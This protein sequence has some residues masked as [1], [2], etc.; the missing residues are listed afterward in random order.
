M[1]ERGPVLL[2]PRKKVGYTRLE[3]KFRRSRVDYVIGTAAAINMVVSGGPLT[4][5][6]K[7][8]THPAQISE[9]PR[10]AAR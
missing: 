2:G 9:G 10:A 8:P 4:G 5:H 7:K 3:N 1:E 6:V